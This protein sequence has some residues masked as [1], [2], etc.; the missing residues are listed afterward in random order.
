[1]KRIQEP[2]ALYVAGQW[3][4]VTQETAVRILGVH[5]KTAQRWASGAQRISPERALLLAILS[6]QLLPFHG[7]EGF[8]FRLR[9]GPPPARRP[10]AVMV[11]PDGR[12]WLPDDFAVWHRVSGS[13]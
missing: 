6:G 10:F 12:E 13:R 7:W 4:Y 2:I 1:M 5:P 8:E 9:Q 3:L 11:S